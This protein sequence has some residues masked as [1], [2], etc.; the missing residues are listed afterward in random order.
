MAFLIIFPVIFQ[1]VIS[2][3]ECCSLDAANVK[4]S[5]GNNIKHVLQIRHNQYKSSDLITSPYA[6]MSYRKIIFQIFV[7]VL[8]FRY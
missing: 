5:S 1:T 6:H 7:H 4:K 2:I 8:P 3:S